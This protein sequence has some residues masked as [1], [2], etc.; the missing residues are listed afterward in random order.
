QPDVTIAVGAATEVLAGA[1]MI[2]TAG[3]VD[4]RIRF[5]CPQQSEEA[6]MSG[7]T[8]MIGGGTG[9][10]TGT[11]A[12]TVTPGPWHRARMLQASDA[13]P[14]NIGVTGKGNVSLPGP[15]IEQ[16]KAGAIGPKLHEDWGTTPA[17]IDNCLSVADENDVPVAIHT[18]TPNQSRLVW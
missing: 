10:A 11:N 3:G 8:T 12:T 6:L 13:F 7:V 17:A 5:S 9:P 16:V 4:T 18:D 14:M 2:L 15:L 1:G